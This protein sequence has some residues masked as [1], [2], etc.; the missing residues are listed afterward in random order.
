MH[1]PDDDEI[2][3]LGRLPVTAESIGFAADELAACGRCGRMN[4]PTRAACLYCGAALDVDRSTA[5]RELRRADD[6]EP[7]FT[8]AASGPS[9][10]AAFAGALIG[11][12]ARLVEQLLA[13]GEILPLVRLADREDADV[14]RGE[15]ERSGMQAFMFADDELMP[16]RPPRRLRRLEFSGDGVV[17]TPFSEADEAVEVAVAKIALVVSGLIR[18]VETS[19]SGRRKRGEFKTGETTE[20]SFDESVLDV[21]RAG[22]AIGYRVVTTGF[23]FSGLGGEMAATAAANI[24]RL[25]ER[26]VEKCPSAAFVDSYRTVEHLLR[27]VWPPA[28]SSDFTGRQRTGLMRSGYGRVDR[29]DTAATFTRFSRMQYYLL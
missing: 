13:T 20:M 25:A 24:A 28:A 10:A 5:M 15:L 1:T 27:D 29:S 21:Y 26:L 8:V 6:W 3:R 2:E 7:G 9:G 12:D 23:D 17:L 19:V 18:R 16:S 11:C 22:D 4:A 14:V